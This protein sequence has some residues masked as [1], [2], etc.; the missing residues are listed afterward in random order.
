MWLFSQQKVTIAMWSTSILKKKP[1]ILASSTWNSYRRRAPICFIIA[2]HWEVISN[3]L[4]AK[5]K[6]VLHCGY[7]TPSIIATKYR[8]WINYSQRSKF[9]KGSLQ[10]WY[11]QSEH[12]KKR[13][14]YFVPSEQIASSLPKKNLKFHSAEVSVENSIQTGIRGLRGIVNVGLSWLVGTGLESPYNKNMNINELG[15]SGLN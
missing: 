9:D 8:I 13:V 15:S 7:V 3:Y 12:Q 6:A 5:L 11:G 10:Q 4:S 14:R 1:S 2:A